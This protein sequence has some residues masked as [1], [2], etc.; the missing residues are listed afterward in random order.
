MGI[1]AGPNSISDNLAF[2]IDPANPRSYAGVGTVIYDLSGNGNTSNFTN[3]AFYQNYQK[4]VVVVDGNNDYISTPIFNLTSP[5]TVSV[6]VKNVVDE[7]FIMGAAGPGINNGNGEGIFY[8][9]GKSIYIQGANTDGKYYQFPQLNLNQWVNLIMTRDV[10]NNMRVYFNGIGSTSNPQSHSNTIQ[11]N[12]IGRFSSYTNQYNTR[13]SIGEVKIYNRALSA[14]EV[15]QNYNASKKRYV[16]EENYVT[17]NLV[18]N[19]DF[20]DTRCYPGTGNTAYDLTGLGHTASLVNG[21]ALNLLYGGNILCD[22]TNDYIEVQTTSA[23]DFGA[24]NFSVEY[25][26]RKTEWTTAFENIWGPNIWRAGGDAVNNEWSLG[27]GQGAYATAGIGESVGFYIQTQSFGIRGSGEH[28][29]V[30]NLN[31]FNQIVG[32]RNGDLIQLY[33]NGSVLYSANPGGGFDNTM[34]LNNIS[35]N[36]R[37]CNSYLDLYHSKAHTGIL[38]IYNKAL[39]ATEVNQNYRA[40][41]PRFSD[42]ALI[43]DGL[44]LNYDFGSAETYPGVGTNAQN[45]VGTELNGTLTN[46]PTYSTNSGGS[47]YLDGTN[48]YIGVTNNSALQPTYLTVEIWFKLNVVLASQPTAYPLL[49]DKYSLSS[50]TGYRLLFERGADELQFT[51]FDSVQD[52]KAAIIGAGAK[53]SQNWNCVQGTFDGNT[54]KIYLNGVLQQTLTRTFSISYNNEDLYLGTYYAVSDG[55]QHYINAYLGNV[56]I[57][58]RALSQS[59]ISQNFNAARNRFGI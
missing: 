20:G 50:L 12:Q 8:F 9:G 1:S 48:D 38:R 54:T 42:P 44:I 11:M 55:F 14:S 35:N 3:G 33:Y 59:E 51:V 36:I 53:L 46:S 28:R 22:G 13:G 10:G 21:A 56:R 16:P 19:L 41:L 7:S 5:V 34:Q 29:S 40:M 39:S 45:L 26:Y 57:Y 49:L 23:L 58:N 6:W 25:W 37:I 18:V 31:K 27:I 30:G 2:H 4:G 15:L 32:I 43:T 17:S 52:N 47:I 24:N